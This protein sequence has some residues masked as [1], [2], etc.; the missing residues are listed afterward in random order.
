MCRAIIGPFC[1]VG[2]L[3]AVANL[4][5][6]NTY[7]SGADEIRTHDL[8]IANEALCQLSY[9]PGWGVDGQSTRQRALYPGLW[10]GFEALAG[11]Q[12]M[13]I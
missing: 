7:Q 12:A 9:R 8:F 11:N 3:C 2:R 13:M 4:Y 10:S 1:I 6:A 5:V